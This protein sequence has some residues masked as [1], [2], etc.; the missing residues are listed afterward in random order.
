MVVTITGRGDNPRCTPQTV[1]FF[2]ES[3]TLFKG[4]D[5]D[6]MEPVAAVPE[7]KSAHRE[8]LAK[9]ACPCINNIYL[10]GQWLNFKLFGITY[11]V[12]KISR[13]NCFFQGPGRLSEYTILGIVRGIQCFLHSTM[14]IQHYIIIYIPGTPKGC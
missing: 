3:W 13:S 10:L 1:V 7:K 5:F 6:S 11:L 8:R 4:C 2:L 14:G 12:G 9:K